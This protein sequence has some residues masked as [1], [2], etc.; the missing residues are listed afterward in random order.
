MSA[1]ATDYDLDPLADRLCTALDHNEGLMVTAVVEVPAPAPPALL[2]ALLADIEQRIAAAL[3]AALPHA[4]MHA[5]WPGEETE[6]LLSALNGSRDVLK[7][8]CP[9]VLLL[10]ED[11]EQLRWLRARTPDLLSSI[12]VSARLEPRPT[13]LDPE[14]VWARIDAHQH[15]TLGT[16]RL[17]GLVP[18]QTAV[19]GLRLDRVYLRRTTLRI[20]DQGGALQLIVGEPG[21]GKSTLLKAR[22]LGLEGGDSAGAAP[23]RGLFLPLSAWSEA[24]RRRSTPLD[25]WVRDT[26]SAMAGVQAVKLAGLLSGATLLL[27]G[28]DEVA[29]LTDRRRL[30]DEAQALTRAYPDLHIVVSGRELV[31]EQLL[32]DH[33]R[34]WTLVRLGDIRPGEAR[35][36]M[37]VTLAAW[38]DLPADGPLPPEVEG[39]AQHAR[40]SP[41]FKTLAHSPL[42]VT[43]YTVLMELQREPPAHIPSLYHALVEMLVVNWQAM[44]STSGARLSRAEAYRTLAP[45]GWGL[46]EAGA[47]GLHKAEL[48]ARLMDADTLSAPGPEREAAARRRLTQLSED[49]ALLMV[50]DGRWRFHHQTIAEF[51][52]ARAALQEPAVAAALEA[53]PYLPQ[54]QQTVAFAVSM[55]LDVDPRDD[56]AARWLDALDRKARRPGVYDAKIPSTLSAVLVHA[57]GLP[58]SRRAALT[59]HLARVTF[60]QKL[61]PW[62]RDLAVGAWAAAARAQAIPTE[63]LE[64]LA[65][66]REAQHTIGEA[67]VAL[68][69][70]EEPQL[71]R[72]LRTDKQVGHAWLARWLADPAPEQRACAWLAV[73]WTGSLNHKKLKRWDRMVWTLV[74]QLLPIQMGVLKQIGVF[75]PRR[76]ISLPAPFATFG[77]PSTPP[78]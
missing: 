16:V 42:L 29:H 34:A 53:E 47:V 69:G 21:S 14:T 46:V 58:A 22:A 20:A 32:V 61:S 12:T 51:L 36:L 74:R 39:R 65:D 70:T 25:A 50:E 18:H 45:L 40:T 60:T 72:W 59:G 63:A 76:R 26:M 57:R 15:K 52:A 62:Q 24:N 41:A 33:R 7:R 37:W 67:L 31:L 48:L 43:F 68:V 35:R 75:K 13:A 78:A 73:A 11:G 17:S 4:R 8:F 23:A 49:S 54:R 9:L 2:M 71:A 27:D 10:I 44:R 6:D 19:Q 1:A 77:A 3:G 30:L 5:I 55:V 38:H 28:L 66:D 64:A 56:L